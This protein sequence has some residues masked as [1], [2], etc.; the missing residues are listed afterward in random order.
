MIDANA[1][2]IYDNRKAASKT[3]DGSSNGQQHASAREADEHAPA[4]GAPWDPV[5]AAA[6]YERRRQARGMP[7]P[8]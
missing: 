7:T 2:V 4:A 5:N 1:K 6:I 8:A 3:R